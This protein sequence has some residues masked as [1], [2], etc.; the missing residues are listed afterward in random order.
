[1]RWEV[2]LVGAWFLGSGI[3]ACGEDSEADEAPIVAAPTPY[4]PDVPAEPEPRLD[5]DALG[6]ALPELAWLAMHVDLQPTFDLYQ[7]LLDRSTDPACPDKTEFASNAD[8]T[9]KMQFWQGVCAASDGTYYNGFGDRTIYEGTTTGFSMGLF[10]SLADL[11]TGEFL[12]GTGFLLQRRTLDPNSGVATYEK[13]ID[14][15]VLAISDDPLLA[16]AVQLDAD[17][18]AGSFN[19]GRFVQILGGVTG[20]DGTITAA[21]FV[22]FALV[23]PDVGWPCGG[24]PRGMMEVRDEAGQWYEIAFDGPPDEVPPDFDVSACDGCGAVS[25]RGEVIGTAC[26]DFSALLIWEDPL[27]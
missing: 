25:F 5:L 12:Q 21:N 22:D 1:M 23:S 24:E 2:V 18:F 17:V 15:G 7:D 26:A 11:K 6:E 27:W 20:I 9:E 16:G 8:M 4:D 13:V 10:A 14:A 3:A 19:P